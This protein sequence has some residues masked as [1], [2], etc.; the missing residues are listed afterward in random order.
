MDISEKSALNYENGI[1]SEVVVKHLQNGRMAWLNNAC[2]ELEEKMDGR[3][4]SGDRGKA[5]DNILVDE[6]HKVLYC[7]VPKAGCSTWR[8][9]LMNVY[10]NKSIPL[11]FIH[12]PALL[13]R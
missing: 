13:Q 7:Y 3:S 9:L 6:K 5:L 8:S 4:S 12:T 1:D 10:N 11:K 2:E